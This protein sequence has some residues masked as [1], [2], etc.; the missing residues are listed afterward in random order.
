ML[1]DEQVSALELFTIEQGAEFN[2]AACP[3]PKL[4][5]YRRVAF[6]A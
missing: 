3:P 5:H 6:M 1:M 2:M 4:T